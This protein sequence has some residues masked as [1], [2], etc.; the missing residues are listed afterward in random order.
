[1]VRRDERR[2]RR[3]YLKAAGALGVMGTTGLSGCTA[4]GGG[5]GSGTITIAAAVPETGPLSSVG[6][7][8]LHGYRLGVDMLNQDGGVNGN[9]VELLVQDD[10]SDPKQVRQSLQQ[11]TS[12]N[13]VDVVW[14]SFSSPLVMAG[15]AVAE[16]QGLPF[17][18]VA[19]CFQ[20][21]LVS[22]G[23]EWTYTPF[24]KTRDVTRATGEIL[25]LVP[26]GE[27]PQKIG[28]WEENS[29]WGA[30]MA[31]AW[32]TKLTDAGYDVVLR[33]T[34]NTGNSDFSTLIS[35]SQ[36]AGVEAL[37]GNP[38]P[39]DGITAMKQLRS[40]GYMPK[41]IEFVR[42]SDPQAWWSALGQ[43]GAGVLMSPGWVPGMTGNGNEALMSAYREKYA[44]S[45]TEIPRVMVG[46]GY[47][48][49][50]TTGQAISAAGSSEPDA[51]TGALDE[52]EFSTVIGEFTFD[53][54]GMP[55]PGQLSA[56]SAQWRDG[57]QVLVYPQTERASDL[58]Y[59]IDG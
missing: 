24:P 5:G 32:E 39:P 29:G 51:I 21:P 23:K 17:L 2:S 9:E 31:E 45:E 13:D 42:A 59:P 55:E 26:E 20:E 7:E 50:Q 15:S 56:A 27:R 36:S 44:E 52:E 48:L 22:G 12:N 37:L 49:A 3:S 11:L 19:T 41:F 1:M 40:S 28:I 35:Q 6:K 53:Q 54:Y 46:V 38:V 58:Q 47:N 4:F 30:E 57:E 33:E 14:G 16:Q 8:M 10:E 43:E 18:A 25:G 34:Y